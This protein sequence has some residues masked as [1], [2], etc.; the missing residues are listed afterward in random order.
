MLSSTGPLQN[1][2]IVPLP[3]KLPKLVLLDRDGVIN[4]DVGAPG[5]LKT[6]QLE[7]TEGAASAI[8]DICRAGC[9]IAIVT[10][11]SC[12]GK[13]LITEAQLQR[14][15]LKLI[16]LLVEQDVDAI[17]HPK[18]ILFCTSV[19]S[20]SDT[21]ERMKPSPGMV[22]EAC[23]LFNVEAEDCVLIGDAIRDLQAAMRGNVP[24]RILVETGYGR[25][26]MNG[27][28]CSLECGVELVDEN[29]FQNDD[30]IDCDSVDTIADVVPF[31]YTPNL[32]FAVD[33]L[34]SDIKHCF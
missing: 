26:L 30:S 4:E 34:L 2:F 14:I 11:Q 23:N 17:I 31:Y 9:H 29:N 16:D 21:D 5:V 32:R 10:N 18:N 15:H 28:S 20:N 19:K 24:T 1:N 25:S 8:G 7:L 22:K 12:V 33:W 6:S 3:P 27:H 13:G